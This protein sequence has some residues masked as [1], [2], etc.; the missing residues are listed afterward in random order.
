M[1]ANRSAMIFSTVL[2]AVT[3]VVLWGGA[4]PA[5]TA[6]TIVVTAADPPSGAQ[7]TIN[8]NVLIKG[9][10]FKTGAI[11]RFYKTGTSDPAGIVVKSTT[12]RGATELVANIDIADLA[13]LS[14]FDIEVMNV[15]GR[16]GKGTD[17][18]ALRG[19]PQRASYR[20][21]CPRSVPP[22]PAYQDTPATWIPHLATE[23]GK[24]ISPLNMDI[25]R[26]EVAIDGEGRIVI[27]GT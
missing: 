18:S 8:L 20:I 22:S 7:G 4:V 12:Y 10:G 6:Q 27:G 24:V 17:C 23:L 14:K 2:I 5:A 3:L 1:T 21:Y 15:G 26:G 16:T 13:A 25:S 11:A 9:K 19:N